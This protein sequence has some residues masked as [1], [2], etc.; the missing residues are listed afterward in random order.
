M[1]GSTGSRARFQALGRTT[2]AFR[3]WTAGMFSCSQIRQFVSLCV[4]SCFVRVLVCVG[5]YFSAMTRTM[6]CCI[7]MGRGCDETAFV[8]I[9]LRDPLMSS[10]SRVKSDASLSMMFAGTL[11]SAPC[12]VGV[13]KISIEL[14]SRSLLTNTALKGKVTLVRVHAALL[15]AH[16]RR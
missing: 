16:F 3:C 14:L 2:L 4:A 13:A 9:S 8:R 1:G 12:E 15:A 5:C 6:C 11:A 7:V 10:C